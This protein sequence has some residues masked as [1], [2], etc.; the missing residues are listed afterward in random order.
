LLRQYG[1]EAM[2]ALKCAVFD[3]L[4]RGD[5]VPMNPAALSRHGR[6]TVRV[7]LRQWAM[8]HAANASLQR[9]AEVFDRAGDEAE[10]A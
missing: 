6:A 5:D 1:D 4:D 2:W 3:A 7:A 8:T 10:A 9:W